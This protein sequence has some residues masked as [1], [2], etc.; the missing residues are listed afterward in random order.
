MRCANH[1]VVIALL[2]FPLVGS[3]GCSDVKFPQLQLG[4][5]NQAAPAKVFGKPPSLEPGQFQAVSLKKIFNAPEAYDGK[6]LRITGKI[7]RVGLGKKQLLPG[8]W[9][10][11]G[12]SRQ[13]LRVKFI[14]PI[15]DG[16]VPADAQGHQAMV[17]G[18]LSWI[19]FTEQLARYYASDGGASPEEIAQIQ[20]P[21]KMLTMVATG[22]QIE[23]P[24]DKLPPPRPSLLATSDIS[25][26]P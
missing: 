10:S 26:A 20:G 17:E 11:M 12:N 23:D 9:I 15:G 6:Y 7:E 2:C 25:T 8:S 14:C 16:L 21:Q 19:T 13:R 18:R 1:R 5:S 24:D 4:V 3:T 22:V